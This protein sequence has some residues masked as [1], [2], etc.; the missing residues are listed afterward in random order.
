[1]GYNVTDTTAPGAQDAGSTP[2][3]FN[4]NI[5][6]VGS[7]LNSI[8]QSAASSSTKAFTQDG[9]T[10]GYLNSFNI[11]STG[12]ITGVY[13]NGSNRVLGQIALATFANQGG[14]Q[15]AGDSTY[16]Q[17]NNSG[18]A[19][20]GESGIAGKGTMLAGALEMSNVDLTDQFTDMIVTQRGFQANSKTIQTAD[21]LLETGLSLKR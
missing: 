21:T 5:G 1:V 19:E 6:E 20:V 2:Q 8:T 10:M 11:D 14:L 12:T 15:K 7:Q 18:L 13:S 3:I 9:Y 17:S 16:V 4:L